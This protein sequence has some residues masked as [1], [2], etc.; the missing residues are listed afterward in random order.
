[1]SV[2]HS[3]VT[4]HTSKV[5][6]FISTFYFGLVFCTPLAT[7]MQQIALQLLL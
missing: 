6:V 3:I 7:F 2:V 4:K 5:L 1:M